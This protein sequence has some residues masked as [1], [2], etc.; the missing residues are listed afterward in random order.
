MKFD[1]PQLLIGA[2]FGALVATTVTLSQR[3][4]VPR[5]S[6]GVRMPSMPPAVTSVEPAEGAADALAMFERVGVPSSPVVLKRLN[7]NLVVLYDRRCEFH[8]GPVSDIGRPMFATRRSI[9]K[10]R[11]FTRPTMKMRSL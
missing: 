3:N 8:C 1:L 2:G 11:N 6:A 9:E 7:E 5:P 10:T 4:N